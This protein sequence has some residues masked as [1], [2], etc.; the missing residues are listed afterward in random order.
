MSWG[1]NAYNEWRKACLVNMYNESVFNANLKDLENL[2]KD[3]LEEALCHFVPE[4][5]K[6]KGDGDYPGE[7]LNE[8]IVS[9]QKYLNVNKI[10]WK[11]VDGPDFIT[12]RT[13]LDNVMRERAARNIG[14]LTKQAEVITYEY[15]NRLWDTGVLGE[16]S[17]QKLRDTVLFLLGINLALRAGDEHYFLRRDT[18][19]KN[20]QISFERDSARVRCLVYREDSVTK[21]NSG[22]VG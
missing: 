15:E 7:T 16:D 1:V 17:P 13:V 5:T 20:S 9:I 21:T 19:D 11:L 2:Q 10:S 18:P 22:G 4:V 8:K 6:S 3:E 12:L 14:M